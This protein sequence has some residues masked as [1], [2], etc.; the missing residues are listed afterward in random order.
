MT[1]R[2]HVV[3][4]GNEADKRRTMTPDH[5]QLMKA[6]LGSLKSRH[7]RTEC[8]IVSSMRGDGNADDLAG[9]VG[10]AKREPEDDWEGGASRYLAKIERTGAQGPQIVHSSRRPLICLRA[11]RCGWMATESGPQK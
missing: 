5:W 4:G 10:V 3:K 11:P 9:G 7:R 1:Q 8:R 6:L 2:R